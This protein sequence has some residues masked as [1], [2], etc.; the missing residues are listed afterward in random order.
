VAAINLAAVMDAIKNTAVSQGVIARAYEYPIPD[1]TPPCL[2]VGWPTKLDFDLTFK[3]GADEA[4]FPV[5][6]LVSKVMDRQARNALSA[7]ITGATGIKDKLDGNLGGVVQ[8]A[9]VV[10]CK[11]TALTITGIDYLAAEFEMDVIT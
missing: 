3:R 10:N 6:F 9:T 2:I 5:W 11:V 1:P 7:I 8:S 4:T